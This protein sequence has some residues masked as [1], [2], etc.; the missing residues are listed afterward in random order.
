MLRYKKSTRPIGQVLTGVLGFEPRNAWVRAMCL[1]A[2]RYPNNARIIIADEGRSCKLFLQ[3]FYDFLNFFRA[4]PSMYA[5]RQPMA[6]QNASPMSTSTASGRP[7]RGALQ[8][9][10]KKSIW[11]R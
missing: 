6:T 5:H 3:D 11:N 2:W 10:R 1:T 9:S 7:D 4:R 8:P